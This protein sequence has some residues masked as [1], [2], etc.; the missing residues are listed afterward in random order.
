MALSI[1]LCLSTGRNL[2]LLV[3]SFALL[4]HTTCSSVLLVH[5]A[6]SCS[7]C[8]QFCSTSSHHLFSC[9]TC[10][11]DANLFWFSTIL[12]YLSTG[13]NFV[14]VVHS[15]ALLLHTTCSFVLLVHRTQSCFTWPQELMTLS[16][17]FY[18]TTGVST[19]HPHVRRAQQPQQPHKPHPSPPPYWHSM[20]V[21]KKEHWTLV[22]PYCSA[23][24]FKLY[25]LEFSIALA[26]VFKFISWLPWWLD[27]FCLC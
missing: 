25:K 21:D 20:W 10:P 22:V 12:L 18:L 17:F 23:C 13:R 5:R 7:G 26:A 6:Q 3:H 19:R 8:P 9:S 14:L 24:T 16:I 1:L 2:V 27:I 4:V 15:F 11:Q